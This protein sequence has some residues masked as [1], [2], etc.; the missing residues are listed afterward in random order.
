MAAP[1]RFC[2]PALLAL[3]FAGCDDAGESAGPAS[4]SVPV[5]IEDSAGVRIVEYAGTPQAPTLTLAGDPVYTHGAGPDDYPFASITGGV[6]YPD[7]SAAVF[8]WENR[9]IVLLGP[10]GTLRDVLSG[11]GEGPGEISQYGTIRITG[12]RGDTLLV[13]DDWNMRLTLFAG[14][15]V[16]FTSRMPPGAGGIGLRALGMGES[17]RVLMASTPM[18]VMPASGI[19]FDEPWLTG[20]LIRFD[21][22]AQV[23]DTVADYDWLP[24][25]ERESTGLLSPSGR[26]GVVGGEFVHGRNDKPEL[27]WRRPDGTVRQIM[28]W[29]AGRLLTSAA[30]WEPFVACMHDNLREM[31]G[32]GAT[33]ARFEE[34]VARW[35]LDPTGPEPLFRWISGDDA[36]RIWLDNAA[37]PPCHPFRYTVIGTD[38]AWLGVFEPPEWFRLVT[39]AG[40]RA[41]GVVTDEMDVPSVV[42][43]DIVGW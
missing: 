36:G 40:G 34:N 35:N 39:V 13:E 3:A 30:R 31:I 22:S 29:A 14:R 12:G 38:G 19:Q 6:L 2:F 4:A 11:P 1:G 25:T 20:H 32:P 42:V 27:T 37:I 26:V 21:V 16:A 17:G 8:D 15:A 9:E 10:G 41:L 18:S 24:F 7:G 33:E 23:A 28:R 43:Y 5:H